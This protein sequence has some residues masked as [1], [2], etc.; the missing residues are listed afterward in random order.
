MEFP[1]KKNIV[2]SGPQ[3]TIDYTFMVPKGVETICG[4]LVEKNFFPDSVRKMLENTARVGLH[5]DLN[6]RLDGHSLQDLG[7]ALE[8]LRMKCPG[9]ELAQVGGNPAIAALRGYFLGVRNRD[10]QLPIVAYVGILPASFFDFLAKQKNPFFCKALKEVFDTERCVQINEW[11]MTLALEGQHKIILAYSVGRTLDY[12][13]A[14]NF[15]QYIDRLRPMIPET[16]ERRVL[17]AFPSI[18]HPVESAAK[19][20]DL[21]T[22]EFGDNALIFFGCS[23]FRD[24]NGLQL[25]RTETLWNLLL[26]KAHILSM[27]ET[28]LG[29]LHTVVVGKGFHQEKPLAYKLLELPTEAIKVCHGA[30]G[31]LMDPGPDAGRVINA[32]A[33]GSDPA[34]FLEESLRLATDGATYGLA[35]LF[36]HDA[37]EAGVRI[38]SASVLNRNNERFR[39]TFLN[40]LESMPPGL[41]AIHTPIVARPMSAL[42]GVGARFDGLL[43]TFLMRS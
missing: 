30:D 10:P 28:E 22:K 7:G 5:Q 1:M 35:S 33:F 27:N 25:E 12:L 14:D 38:F 32:T 8:H 9:T 18:P 42:T 37:T 13:S 21:I 20:I 16:A 39:T 2:F 4:E 41:I 43:A 26:S 29:D 36:G 31:A 3:M 11:P 19:L 15:R 24:A 17:F 23:S 34:A 40:V 6:I